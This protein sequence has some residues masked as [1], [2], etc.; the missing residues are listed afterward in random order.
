MEIIPREVR[1]V[2][3]INAK[4][5]GF[6]F[7]VENVIFVNILHQKVNIHLAPSCQLFY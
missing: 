7:F 5:D 6:L 2:M 3:K 1:K 4:K